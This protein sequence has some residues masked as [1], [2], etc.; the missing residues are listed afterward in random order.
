MQS[1]AKTASSEVAWAL[2]IEG[3]AAARLEAH[4]IRHLTTRSEKLVAES[5]HR[6]HIYQV[7]GDIVEE[8]PKRLLRLEILLD[9]TALALVGMGEGFLSARLPLSEKQLV[10]EAT[11]SAFGGGKDKSSV[12]RVARAY[13]LQHVKGDSK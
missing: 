6:D 2:L 11:Q 8:M 5:T 10:E 9:R 4:R 12:Q 13:M 3:V 1:H 7:A